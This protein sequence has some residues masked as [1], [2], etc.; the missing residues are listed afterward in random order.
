MPALRPYVVE[1]F[2]GLD[3]INDEHEIGSVAATNLLNVD[4]D[5]NGRLRMRDGEKKFNTNNLGGTVYGSGT[6]GSRLNNG[7]ILL[8]HGANA[9]AALVDK[10]DQTGLITNVGSLAGFGLTAPRASATAHFG[11]AAGALMYITS[12]NNNATAPA[13]GLTLQ[14]YNGAALAASTGRPAFVAAYRTGD[15]LIQGHYALAA[16]SPSGANGSPSTVFISDTNLP[17]T[18]TATNFVTLREGD[19][20]FIT[21]IVTWRQLTF[22]FKQTVMYVFYGETPDDDGLP[23]FNKRPVTLPTSIEYSTLTIGNQIVVG[24]DGVYFVSRDGLYRTDGNKVERISDKIQ[25]IF[26][27]NADKTLPSELAMNRVNIPSYLFWAGDR[28]IMRYFNLFSNLVTLVWDEHTKAFRIW[29]FANINTG[30]FASIPVANP[31]AGG[32]VRIEGPVMFRSNN[33]DVE[34][35]SPSFYND[36]NVNIDWSYTSGYYNLDGPG[37]KFVRYVDAYGVGTA[38]IEMIRRANRTG[39]TS[40]VS[41]VSLATPTTQASPPTRARASVNASGRQFAHK[42]GGSNSTRVAIHRLEHFYSDGRLT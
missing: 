2:E 24:N 12:V 9:S 38:S 4:V 15:R 1:R 26:S 16:H 33:T 20:E 41:T 8:V 25:P 11:L 14:K 27:T 32:D 3:L 6:Y 39:S 40:I 36:D 22:V 29:S 21:G 23:I 28:L 30:G 31:D 35:V 10:M 19:G 18:Y 13:T 37:E 34:L 5:R 7:E 42:L 17:D